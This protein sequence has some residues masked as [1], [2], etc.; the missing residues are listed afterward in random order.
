MGARHILSS[1]NLYSFKNHLL[2]AHTVPGAV[3]GTWDTSMY[4]TRNNSGPRE[5]LLVRGAPQTPRQSTYTWGTAENR[6]NRDKCWENN[7]SVYLESAWWFRLQC[8]IG[9]DDCGGRW[10]WRSRKGWPQGHLEKRA[11][12]RGGRQWKGPPRQWVGGVLKWGGQHGWAEESGS[13][14]P[15]PVGPCRPKEG[16]WLLLWMIH[17]RSDLNRG[18]AWSNVHC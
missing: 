13:W 4:K 15:G 16:G 8:W 9:G 10:H 17:H 14:G 7:S 1:L 12:C 5:R 2:S 18:S 3:L 6:P 11:P